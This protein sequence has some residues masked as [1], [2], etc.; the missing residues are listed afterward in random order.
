[1]ASQPSVLNAFRLNAARLNYVPAAVAVAR[2]TRMRF[3]LNG[4]E[5][6][7][8]IRVESVSIT[9]ALN[10]TP[11]TAMWIMQGATPTVAMAVQIWLNS[12]A[13]RLLFSGTIQTVERSYEGVPPLVVFRCMGIDDGARANRRLPFASWAMSASAVG[14]SLLDFFA[15]GFSGAGIQGGLP[16]V[17]V[18]FDGTEGMDGALKQVAKLIGGYY[19]FDNLTLHLYQT[20]SITPPDPIDLAHPPLD[21][22]P[23]RLL[24]DQ[25]QVRTRVYGKGH[26]EAALADVL[27]S[28]TLVPIA[29]VVMFNASGGRA[30]TLT[31][32]LTYTGTAAGGY[33]S[34]VGP[35]VTAAP[36]ALRVV[37]GGSV[38]SGAHSYA[39]TFYTA[40]GET[41][42]GQVAAIVVGFT[43]PP[44]TAMVTAVDQFGGSVDWGVHQYALTFVTSAGETVVGPLSP[45]TCYGA[46]LPIPSYIP[47]TASDFGGSLPP[48]TYAHA[49]T[50]V[51][52]YGETPPGPES[53]PLT[54]PPGIGHITLNGIPVGPT[55]TTAKNV[56]R[57]AGNGLRYLTTIAN[58]TTTFVDDGSLTAGAVAPTTNTTKSGAQYKRV[59]LSNI[60]LGDASITNRKLYR[61]KADASTLLFLTTLT[62]TASSYI[63]TAADSTL[64]AGVPPTTSTATANGVVLA[65]PTGGTPTVGRKIYRSVAG[66]T[67]P[68]KLVA[69]IADNTTTSYTDT[70][71]DASLGAAPPSSDTSNLTQPAGEV[72]GGSSSIPLASALP[73]DP[74][75]GWVTIGAQVVRYTGIS[76]NTLTGLPAT[77]PGA[78]VNT[79]RFGEHADRA[80]ILAGC[81]LGAPIHKGDPVNIFVQVDDAVAQANMAALDGGDGIY[82]HLITDE[83]RGESSLRDLCTADLKIFGA[84]LQTLTYA[85]RDVKS[86]SGQTVSVNL[87]SIGMAVAT[88]MIQTVQISEIDL[89]PGLAPRYTVVASSVRFSLEDLL[90]QLADAAAASG[91]M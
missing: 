1:M 35:G 63:D 88:L 46:P 87:P 56:Y 65:I 85:T 67:T 13:P 82:E 16:S 2:P 42:P 29:D 40:A 26:S 55:G 78:L 60:P 20:E 89:R 54:L 22:P 49:I 8:N 51:D 3:L 41:I 34:L 5:S 64:G 15:P 10:D 23:I 45:V 83:R 72:P 71:A 61:T 66:T 27:I 14:Q 33:G 9:D 37:P 75:G 43:P 50:F 48:G 21:D 53:P 12:D 76:G 28:D 80:P 17:T 90:R 36:P 69:T 30:I 44:A 91:G 6:R 31:Q 62:P 7:T 38:P 84:P 59:F 58:G 74:A 70:I 52:P 25:S 24:T 81:V 39:V 19:Y 4:V 68:L 79:I 73:F 86:K 32:R 57:D 11:N 18:N 77:G 47:N